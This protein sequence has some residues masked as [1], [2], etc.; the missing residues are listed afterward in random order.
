MVSGSAGELIV[1]Q[2]GGC[3]AQ[4]GHAKVCILRRVDC[5]AV[6]R[7]SRRGQERLIQAARDQKILPL[8]ADIADVERERLRQTK[9]GAQVPLVHPGNDVLRAGHAVG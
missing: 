2:C 4:D 5:D 9:L 8:G 6:H 7:I 1:S 3:F